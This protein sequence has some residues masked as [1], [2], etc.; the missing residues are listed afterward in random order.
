MILKEEKSACI[1]LNFFYN[2]TKIDIKNYK[3]VQNKKQENFSEIENLLQFQKTIKFKKAEE[4]ISKISK[5]NEEINSLKIDQILDYFSDFKSYKSNWKDL[6]YV[7]QF[8]IEYFFALWKKL[9]FEDQRIYSYF[10][11][12][13]IAKKKFGLKNYENLLVKAEFKLLE[14][15]YIYN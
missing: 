7:D 13:L 6:K 10:F 8:Y 2:F 14:D 1:F 4:K 12:N 3:F 15:V 9:D 5:F 11:Q